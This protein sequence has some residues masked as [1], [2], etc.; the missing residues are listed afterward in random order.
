[1]TLNEYQVLAQRTASTKS[2]DEKR[3]HGNLGLIGEVGEIIDL[4]KKRAYMGMTEDLFREKLIDEAGDV[5]WYVA[6]VCTGYEYDIETYRGL[7]PV[8]DKVGPFGYEA[9]VLHLVERATRCAIN[10]GD[11]RKHKRFLSEVVRDLALLL[12][13][14]NIDI[15]EVLQ[16]NIDKLRA[17]YP[18]GFSAKRSNERYQ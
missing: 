4:I 12:W 1:M 10:E 13:K 18:D 3:G 5:M 11:K 8:M 14:A 7:F 6:E 9:C 17:R 2:L 16:H 15:Q